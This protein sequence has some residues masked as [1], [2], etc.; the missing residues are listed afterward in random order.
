PDSTGRPRT[1]LVTV[2]KYLRGTFNIV[3]GPRME[4]GVSDSS[5]LVMVRKPLADHWVRH[6]L[7]KRVPLAAA[8][9]SGPRWRIAAAS[10]VDVTSPRAT[11][12]VLHLQLRADR[13]D[14]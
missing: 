4:P 3:T 7:L 2:H 5:Q 1:A 11:T 14:T 8:D 6:L 10:G 12:P 9:P 13:R